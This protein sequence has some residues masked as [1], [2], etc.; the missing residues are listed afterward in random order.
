M[1]TTESENAWY[2]ILIEEYLLWNTV[3]L[4]IEQINW[5]FLNKAPLENDINELLTKNW[6]PVVYFKYPTNKQWLARRYNE[7][8]ETKY[9]TCWDIPFQKIVHI[10]PTVL[11]CLISVRISN[12][13]LGEI[14]GIC[15]FDVGHQIKFFQTHTYISLAYDS[16][17]SHAVWSLKFAYGL[18][19]QK[20]QFTH[21]SHRKRTI[22]SK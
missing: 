17:F 4:E 1:A 20:Y 16:L 13:S 5:F 22:E 14:C 18:H 9:S 8:W 21:H 10:V 12:S 2:C 3:R 19:Y 6:T 7:G 11:L 15:I